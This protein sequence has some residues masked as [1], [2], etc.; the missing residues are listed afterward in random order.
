MTDHTDF[1]QTHLDCAHGLMIL[2]MLFFHLSVST[3]YNTPLYHTILHPLSFFIAWFFFKSGMFFKEYSLTEQIKRGFQKLIIPA[4]FFSLIGF[5]CYFIIDK[6][7]FNFYRECGYTYVFGTFHGNIPLWFL[8]SLFIVQIIFNILR[9]IHINPII[10]ASFSL[11]WFFLNK[12][13]GFRPYWTYNIP[14]GLMFVA[15]GYIFKNIQYDTKVVILCIIIYFGLFFCSTE[16]NFMYG[17]FN[18]AYIAMPWALTGC[19]LTNVLFKKFPVLCI[20]PLKF[21][22][23]HAMEFLGTHIIVIAFIEMFIHSHKLSINSI[24]IEFVLFTIYVIVLS[25]ILHFCK[26]NHIQWLFGRTAQKK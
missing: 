11:V 25:T 10:I 20:K 12:Y 22:G 17:K 15:L 14:M 5:I 7:C 4:L 3:I 21:F 24:L 23:L 19:I 13:I 16:I 2:H 9:K 8:Y 26:L 6:P 18:P 1:R